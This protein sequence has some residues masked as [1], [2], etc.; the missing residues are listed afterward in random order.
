MQFSHIT[1]DYAVAPQIALEDM[2]ALAAQGFKTVI[3]NRPDAEV[4]P[5]LGSEAMRAAAEAAGLHYV[6]N[7]VI[8]GAMTLEMVT[9]QGAALADAP[10]PI[11][12]YCRSG[13]RSTIMWALARAG[14][15]PTDA[16][17]AAAAQAGYDIAGMA[18][19]IDALA[20]RG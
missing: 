16:L 15:E 12:A 10:G 7:P 1:P 9:A 3:N 6:E 17:L 2:A 8:N 13:T 4:P 5:A 11:L 20:Q 19:Q 18:G 14:Q